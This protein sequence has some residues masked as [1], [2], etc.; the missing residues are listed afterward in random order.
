MSAGK[1]ALVIIAVLILLVGVG[2]MIGGGALVWSNIVIRDS[3]GFYSTRTINFNRD[4]HAITSRPAEIHY[5]PTWF[6][7]WP[8]LVQIKT[9]ATNNN[10]K[11]IFIG[12]LEEKKVQQYLGN[13]TYDQIRELNI[14]RP[15]RA[16]TISYKQ[17]PGESSP[18]PPT[19]QTF[20]EASVYGQNTQ[21]LKWG[22]QE[23]NY[24]LVV[25]NEDGSRGINIDGSL[26]VKVPMIVGIGIGLLAGGFVLI[27]FSFLVVYLVAARLK[28]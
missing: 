27:L 23:G 2:L 25:M 14:H 8:D 5:G 22:L 16:P 9:K 26:G 18:G 17:Y 1:I 7:N 21:V 10:P 11:G 12:I 4:S 20:W 15:F 28:V 19:S 24:S 13:V 3:E 6:L